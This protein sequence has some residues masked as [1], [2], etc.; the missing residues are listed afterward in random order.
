MDTLKVLFSGGTQQNL[1]NSVGVHTLYFNNA[2]SDTLNIA[3][4]GGVTNLKIDNVSVKE[5]L[6][7]EVVPDSGC[8]SWLLEGQSTNLSTKSEN[9]SGWGFPTNVTTTQNYG[10]SPDGSVNSTRLQFTS[11]G[12]MNDALTLTSGTEYTLSIYAKRNDTGTQSFGFYV[13]GIPTVVG[14]ITL[15]EEWQRFTY[16]Y[17]AS[18]SSSIGLAG[19]SGADV[20][21]FGFQ[22]RTTI[23]RNLIHSN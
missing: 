2:D 14:G 12:F 11:N 13:D 5:V 19:D 17:T 9:I 3:R 22:N 16:T 18:S 8:G 15:T 7:Q 20:S 10:T 21:V 4:L 6:G 23:L 1:P